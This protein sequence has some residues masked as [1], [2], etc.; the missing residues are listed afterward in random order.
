VTPNFHAA[1]NFAS[2][3]T[4]KPANIYE[5]SNNIAQN[6]SAEKYEKYSDYTRPQISDNLADGGINYRQEPSVDLYE[7]R[8][9]Y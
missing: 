4:Y 6:R 3:Y 2:H 7:N 8:K 1:S 5:G 9:S